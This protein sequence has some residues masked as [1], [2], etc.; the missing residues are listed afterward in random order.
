MSNRP[1][2]NIDK[3]IYPMHSCDETGS[4]HTLEFHTR[5]RATTGFEAAQPREGMGIDMQVTST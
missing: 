4:K 2:M 3:S 1:R 5:G